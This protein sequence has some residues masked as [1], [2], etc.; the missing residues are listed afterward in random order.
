M[1]DSDSDTTRTTELALHNLESALEMFEG[2]L[3][4]SKHPARGVAIAKMQYARRFLQQTAEAVDL[5]FQ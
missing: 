2:E 5:S 1:R 3:W 4:R